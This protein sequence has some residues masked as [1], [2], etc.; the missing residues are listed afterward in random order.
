MRPRRILTSR[1]TSEIMQFAADEKTLAVVSLQEGDN[2]VSFKSHFLERDPR[3][4]FFVLD[5]QETHGVSPP[6]LGAGQYV[7][8]SFRYKSR[9]IMFSTVV[10]ARGRYLNGG[11]QS[12]PA[13]R[14]RWP[15]TMVELQRRAYHRTLVPSGA[16]LPAR[17][18][19]GAIHAP[20]AQRGPVLV[21]SS[22]DLSCGGTLIRV[23]N[24][25]DPHWPENATVGVELELPDGR[26]PLTLSAHYKG[27][28]DD[29]SG[30][31]CVAVQFVGLECEPDGRNALQRL[32]RCIQGFHR[33]TIASE[34]HTNATRP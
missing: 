25:A 33:Q 1:E 7:G 11:S 4:R 15:Q 32:A 22:I 18:W 26:S 5:F 10:E 27:A 2:W 24:A 19:H 9:K 23:A 13:V 17:V 6:E 8:V 29:T 31:T 30:A 21:G 3:G 34:L 16:T 28:R 12:V 14:Y 20:P